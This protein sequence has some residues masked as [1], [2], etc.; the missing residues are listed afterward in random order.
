[1]LSGPDP[2]V[3]VGIGDD[4]AVLEPGGGQL[5]FTTDLLLEGIHFERASSSARDLGAKAVTVNVSDVAAMG[6]SPRYA[7][8]AVAVPTDVEAAWVIELMGGMREACAEYALALVGGDTNRAE[9]IVVSVAIVGEVAL[10]RAV[11]RSG[12]R[13]G[14]RI[15]VTGALGA[16]A[17]GLAISKAP[18]EEAASALSEPWGRELSEALARPVARLGEAPILSRVGATSMIDLSDGLAIDLSRLSRASEVGA[19]IS[20]PAIPVAG[21]LLQGAETLGVDALRLALTGGEDYELLATMPKGAVES[22]RAEMLEAFG[23]MLSDIGE[24]VDGSGVV[25]VREDGTATPLEPA[26]WDHF[27]RG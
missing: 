14:D 5:V 21:A 25:A 7:I 12:A 27:G 10:G 3:A 8:A 19:R 15:V 18:P 24:V 16:A 20:L 1:M 9:L 2:G 17:G 13:A 6:A 22:A 26:G 4:A 23:T 11:T